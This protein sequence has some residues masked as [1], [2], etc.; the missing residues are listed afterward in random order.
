[1]DIEKLETVEMFGKRFAQR[2]REKCQINTAF[3][4]LAKDIF[5]QR[6]QAEVHQ[7]RFTQKRPQH[8]TQDHH[9]GIVGSGNRK[10]ASDVSRRKRF[11]IGQI[12]EVCQ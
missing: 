3:G 7:R 5:R 8:G 6:Q 10:R 4:K 2:G 9:D 12:V 11:G 1:M